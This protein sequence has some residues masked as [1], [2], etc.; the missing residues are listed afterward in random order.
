MR[1]DI[2]YYNELI[3]KIN[4]KYSDKIEKLREVRD[5]LRSEGKLEMW[6][7]ADHEVFEIEK[8]K[9]WPR[10]WIFL[11]HESE[12]PNPG[13]YVIRS[14]GPSDSVIVIRDE[15]YNIRVFLNL[16][17]HRGLQLV[18]TDKGNS[19]F[20]TCPYHG[21][22]FRCNGKLVGVPLEEIGY[23]KLNKEEY[24]LI[25]IESKNYYGFVFATFASKESLED[26]LGEIRWYFDILVKR[27]SNGYQ[28]YPVERR[29]IKFN[30]KLGADSFVHDV[31]HFVITHRSA[32]NLYSFEYVKNIISGYQI[33]SK[34]GHNMRFL[35]KDG[36]GKDIPIDF[37]PILYPV[38]NKKVIE[39]AKN[40]LNKQQFE[41]F[42]LAY[43][44]SGFIFPNLGFFNGYRKLPD[45]YDFEYPKSL[46]IPHISFRVIRPVSPDTTEYLN[47]FV[48][49]KDAPEEFKELSH[50]T[51]M[52]GFGAGGV[53]ETDDIEHW[54]NITKG[55][56]SVANYIFR[57]K[58]P[59]KL[60]EHLM[61][62]RDFLGPHNEEL[63]IIPSGLTEKSARFMWLKVLDYLID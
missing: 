55:S 5:T 59:Y 21:W 50:R 4:E 34:K 51:F 41:L 28:F 8:F 63:E 9:L 35:G 6:W 11:A 58:F 49:E 43:H 29:L 13:D 2:S 26:Y 10:T 18:K 23:G 45:I 57:T 44:I 7:I 15:E 48:V 20:I 12:I 33:A 56:Q 38:W 61:S 30:W 62:L 16:C 42:S 54:I 24:N 53:V 25:E 46:G 22:T 1:I 47:W 37:Y 19:R 36:R 3:E 39:E 31:Y 52:N 14:I 40:N 60:G 27:N 17:T 32:T